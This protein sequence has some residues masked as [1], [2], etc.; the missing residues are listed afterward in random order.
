MR[1]ELETDQTATY[2]PQVPLTVAALL[3]HSAGLLNRGSWGPKLSAGSWFSLPRTATRTSTATDPN[4]GPGLYH[5]LT[6][7]CFPW[8]SQL[9]RIQSV[10]TSYL[11]SDAPVSRLTTGS[12]VNILHS[13]TFSFSISLEEWLHDMEFYQQLPACM[14]LTGKRV[15][16]EMCKRGIGRDNPF[17]SKLRLKWE[18]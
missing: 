8:A 3:S 6:Y 18:T 7:T 2:W 11:R 1:G 17:P 15:Q 4:Y 5:C 9:H 13:D 14:I 16:Q 10:H 12:K